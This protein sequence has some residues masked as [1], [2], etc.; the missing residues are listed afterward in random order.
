[1]YQP[2]FR[3]NHS[4]DFCLAQSIDFVLTDMDKQMHTGMILVGLKKAFDTLDQGVLLEK[5]KYFAF[6][7]SV[8]EWFEFYLSGKKI[9]VC[10]DNFFLR[11]EH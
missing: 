6:L 9:L 5:V 10:I 2:G 4:T 8:I 3:T 1:M 11:L 7:T